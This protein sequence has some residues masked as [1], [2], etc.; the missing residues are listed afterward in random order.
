MKFKDPGRVIKKLALIDEHKLKKVEY[1]SVA[2]NKRLWKGK[3]GFY[4][5]NEMTGWLKNYDETRL[6]EM[7][8]TL[9]KNKSGGDDPFNFEE[10]MH[11][12]K[13]QI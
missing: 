4:K 11:R 5:R 1:T 10:L 9:I 8:G 2:E 6:N 7:K 12:E 13:K 3:K